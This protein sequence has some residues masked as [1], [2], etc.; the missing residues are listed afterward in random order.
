MCETSDLKIYSNKVMTEVN[1][2][3][4]FTTWFIVAFVI[5]YKKK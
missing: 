4:L 3:W 2:E 1:K 5:I